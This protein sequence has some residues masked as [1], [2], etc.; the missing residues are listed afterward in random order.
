MAAD[1]NTW[2]GPTWSFTVSD[3]RVVDN[4]ESY[5]D[6]LENWSGGSSRSANGAAVSLGSSIVRT[7]GQSMQ[8]MYDNTLYTNGAEGYSQTSINP[9]NMDTGG[10]WLAGGSNYIVFWVYGD[11]DNAD[12]E[13]M[14]VKIGSR[15][16]R[17]IHPLS[18][19]Q[20]QWWTQ[21][22]IPLDH[23]GGDLMNLSNFSIGFGRNGVN[24]G[25]GVIQVDD[26]RL[27]RVPPVGPTDEIYFEA[28]TP[29]SITPVLLIHMDDP[30]EPD[31]Y[32]GGYIEPLP[33]TGRAGAPD[34]NATA[35]YDFT[36]A[37]GTY[38]MYM[39]AKDAGGAYDSIYFIIDDGNNIGDVD[40]HSS[41]ELEN[42]TW[43][44][45]NS[46]PSNDD[47]WIWMQ[48]Y[49]D[50]DSDRL[51]FTLTPGTHTLKISRREEWTKI[52]AIIIT[53]DLYIE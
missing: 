3:Y 52:D 6:N 20:T 13:Q 25:G 43:I 51:L 23:G 50:S 53:D 22:T 37:G 10:N 34:P 39:R 26:V 29:D 44:R 15:L 4:F 32:G 47:Y 35:T 27:Y 11:V 45:Q 28:E 18:K 38:M 17:N 2:S 42:E 40:V 16:Y 41:G 5:D 8:F 46:M 49:S 21:V 24:A 14:Y 9:R 19:V 31:A 12:T 33:G 1:P 30:N 48:A 7:G 36:V